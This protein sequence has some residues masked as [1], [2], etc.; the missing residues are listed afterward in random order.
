MQAE[1]GGGGLGVVD[2]ELQNTSLLLKNLHVLFNGRD[3]PWTR[4]VWRSYLCSC[5]E[6][7]ML[8]PRYTAPSLVWIRGTVS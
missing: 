1:G 8:V 5:P 7:Y 2:L 6:P 3:T 4:W